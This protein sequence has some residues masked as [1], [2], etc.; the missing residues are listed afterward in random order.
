MNHDIVTRGVDL[1]QF[2]KLE[3]LMDHSYRQSLC[4]FF[5]PSQSINSS[6][7]EISV[8]REFKGLKDGLILKGEGEFYSSV[9]E[10]EK[11][12]KSDGFESRN[13]QEGRMTC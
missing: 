8:A 5:P 11:N 12:T 3:K 9:S 13:G 1:E 4:S 6:A 2:D 7:R 10:I